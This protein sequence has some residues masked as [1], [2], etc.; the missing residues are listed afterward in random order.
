[1]IGKKFWIWEL[2]SSKGVDAGLQAVTTPFQVIQK[3]TL[4]NEAAAASA[5][6]TQQHTQPELKSQ[7]LSHLGGCRILE[8]KT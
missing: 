7:A 8:Q 1:M 2:S 6:K 3:I 4:E 5:Q